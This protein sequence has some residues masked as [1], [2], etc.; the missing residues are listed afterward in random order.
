MEVKNEEKE[1]KIVAI[2]LELED[3]SD[4]L[5]VVQKQLNKLNQKRDDLIQR[6]NV[7]TEHLKDTINKEKEKTDLQDWSNQK[8][9]WDANVKETLQNV[10]QIKNFRPLQ[11]ETINAT[12][13]KKDCILI[14]PTGGGKS[15]CFQLPAVVSKGFS[16][17]SNQGRAKVPAFYRGS[18]RTLYFDIE[19][20]FLIL[21]AMKW[22]GDWFGDTR[23]C[24]DYSET[25]YLKSISSD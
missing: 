22:N 12:L 3:I 19:N 6:K 4:E 13:S 16:L 8:F 25:F 23:L 2:N 11:K 14:M 15:L 1:S 24:K 10:F 20:T 9:L 17:V 21:E 5:Q 7:L 18:L